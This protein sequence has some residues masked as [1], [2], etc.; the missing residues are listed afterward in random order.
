MAWSTGQ[1]TDHDQLQN[2]DHIQYIGRGIYQVGFF[3]ALFN[4]DLVLV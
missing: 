3:I 2:H 1:I 4:A